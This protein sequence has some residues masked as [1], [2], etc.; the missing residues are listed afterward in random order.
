[1]LAVPRAVAAPRRRLHGPVEL[2]R[3]VMRLAAEGMAMVIVTRRLRDVGGRR[4]FMG[5][6]G[7]VEEGEPRRAFEAPRSRRTRDVVARI[8]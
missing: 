1:L 8:L 5:H 4:V 6:G 7:I 3:P 2:S